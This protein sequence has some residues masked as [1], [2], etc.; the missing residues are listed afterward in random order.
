[1]LPAS[2]VLYLSLCAPAHQAVS[3][4]TTPRIELDGMAPAS[5]GELFAHG[6]D[7]NVTVVSKALVGIA[8]RNWSRR[9][10]RSAGAAELAVHIADVRQRD[11]ADLVWL[12][13][14]VREAGGPCTARTRNSD[15]DG[16]LPFKGGKPGGWHKADM[17]I[18]SDLGAACTLHAAI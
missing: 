16:E 13:K 10:G 8:N 4:R 7:D 6:W 9:G 15:P 3:I 17:S 5:Q 12:E 2:Q 18:W 11:L 14:F 1:M